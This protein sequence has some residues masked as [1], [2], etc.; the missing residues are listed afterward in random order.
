[1]EKFN[2][3]ELK[4]FDLIR[5][6]KSR[7][8]ILAKKITTAA[9]MQNALC[10]IY[11]KT[12]DLVKYKTARNKFDELSCYMRNNPGAFDSLLEVEEVEE[13]KVGAAEVEEVK[14]EPLKGFTGP[15]DSETATSKVMK[16]IDR[17]STKL[18]AKLEILDEVKAEIEK[19]LDNE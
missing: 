14:L 15:V 3:I 5:A 4:I 9:N 16:V 12:E 19:E 18:Q 1:M 11:S 13:E 2:S 6:G 17:I 7:S 10:G 8:Q